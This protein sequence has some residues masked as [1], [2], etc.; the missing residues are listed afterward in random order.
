MDKDLYL[1]RIG[2]EGRARPTR[3]T[4]M[5][6][7]RCH[8]ETVP[9]E[10]FDIHLGVAIRLDAPSL[11]RKI[12]RR[13][14]GGFC[15]ELNGLFAWL[16]REVGFSVDMLSARVVRS[17][18]VGE[19]FDHLALRV[20]CEG[21]PYLVDVGFGDGS[22]LPIVLRAGEQ[23]RLGGVS[24]ALRAV[25]GRDDEL[26]YD[27]TLPGGVRKRYEL[28][29]KTREVED[30][31]AMSEHHQTSPDSWFTGARVCVLHTPRGVVS[32]V[33]GTYK[34]AGHLERTIA[35]DGEYLGFLRTRFGVDL[36]RMPGNLSERP[37][38]RLRAKARAT[39][40]ALSL[41]GSGSLGAW[42]LASRSK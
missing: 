31:L 13:Q 3:E 16:L 20:W 9:F 23:H 25:Q 39:M 36:P 38:W 10:N 1:S 40:Q 12:V 34:V 29:L 11:Y 4:L 8:L 41:G 42:A 2:F 32:I 24:Y 17:R 37:I 14:R 7:A 28:S 30:F 27:A 35:D 6:L 15:Y 21:M 33:D 26:L 5:A 19:E 22:T 18:G